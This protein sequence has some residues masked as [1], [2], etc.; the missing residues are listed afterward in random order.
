MRKK[1]GASGS[2]D[3]DEASTGSFDDTV[4]CLRDRIGGGTTEN[5]SKCGGIQGH[6]YLQVE[7]SFTG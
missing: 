4:M 2:E 7:L 6:S 5:E 1:H 3:K